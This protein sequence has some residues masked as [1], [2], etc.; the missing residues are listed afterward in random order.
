MHIGREQF[1]CHPIPF[2]K[3]NAMP[4]RDRSANPKSVNPVPKNPGAIEIASHRSL[5]G[6]QLDGVAGSPTQDSTQ[7]PSE[8]NNG[9]AAQSWLLF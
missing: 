1:P 6:T 4:N 8:L 9:K 7:A 5:F 2:I 3:I